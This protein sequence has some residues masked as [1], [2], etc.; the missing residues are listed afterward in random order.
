MWGTG[1]NSVYLIQNRTK[2][3]SHGICF[4]T[5]VS[6]YILRYLWFYFLKKE[7][8]FSICFFKMPINTSEHPR[9]ARILISLHDLHDPS[10]RIALTS[11]NLYSNY[12]IQS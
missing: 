4:D 5:F 7:L 9:L 12:P 6:W 1:T 2:V 3:P 8:L 11:I 10:L